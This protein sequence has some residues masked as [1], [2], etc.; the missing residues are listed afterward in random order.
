MSLPASLLGLILLGLLLKGPLADRYPPSA[1][2]RKLAPWLAAVLLLI[3]VYSL[4]WRISE[5]Y[6]Q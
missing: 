4:L 5:E 3:F 1:A 2:L 6:W